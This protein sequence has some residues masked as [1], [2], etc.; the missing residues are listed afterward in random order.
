MVFSCCLSTEKVSPRKSSVGRAVPH[1]VLHVIHSTHTL[2]EMAAREFEA[3]SHD[4]LEND[5]KEKCKLREEMGE[6]ACMA[7]RP[8]GA[9]TTR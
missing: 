8:L 3:A 7:T 2:F 1:G 5:S 4:H 6:C 9:W